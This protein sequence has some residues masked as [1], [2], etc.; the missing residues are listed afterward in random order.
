MS[1]AYEF[2]PLANIFPMITGKAFAEL[3]EDI[4]ANGLREKIVLFDGKIGDGRNR[5]KACLKA[6]VEPVFETYEGDDPLAY[7]LSANLH[8][9]HLDDGQR[10]MVAAKIANMRQGA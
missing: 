6:G 3:V 5:Y 7:V 8:R 2:H 9:R 1:T 4:R 10:S